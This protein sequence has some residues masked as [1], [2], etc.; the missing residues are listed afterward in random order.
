MSTG[1]G[2]A[3][4]DSGLCLLLSLLLV[5]EGGMSCLGSMLSIG[6]LAQAESLLCGGTSGKC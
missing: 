3:H 5:V 4:R 1:S 2:A 6:G